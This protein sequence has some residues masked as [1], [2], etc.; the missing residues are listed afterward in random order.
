M[1]NQSENNSK[2]KA[3]EAL[4][5]DYSVFIQAFLYK[6]MK[7]VFEKLNYNSPEFLHFFSLNCEP[8]NLKTHPSSQVWLSTYLEIQ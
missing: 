6:N 1:L 3:A 4:F 8:L 5:C 7:S 2:D